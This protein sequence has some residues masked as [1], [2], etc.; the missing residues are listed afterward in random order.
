[1]LARHG[2]PAADLEDLCHEVFLI[3]GQRLSSVTRPEFLLF[4][5]RGVAWRV[6]VAHRRRNRRRT[7]P[8]TGDTADQASESN[9][10]ADEL[11]R[12]QQHDL[13]VRAIEHLDLFERDALILH[14]LAELPLVEV[15]RLANCDPKTARKRLRTAERRVKAW[16]R[17]AL[18]EGTRVCAP[19]AVAPLRT[20]KVNVPPRSPSLPSFHGAKLLADGPTL[21]TALLGNV[22][23]AVWSVRVTAVELDL[24]EE[25]ANLALAMVGGPFLH[26]AI[27]E[28]RC[29][30][31]GVH[32]RARM[33]AMLRMF[34]RDVIAY[35]TVMK[36][37]LAPLVRPVI[38]AL[39]V[40]ARPGFPLAFF[41]GMSA[42]AAWLSEKVP[43]HSFPDADR[44]MATAAWLR[45]RANDRGVQFSFPDRARSEH[46]PE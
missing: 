29:R 3:A 28:P 44:L 19:A 17:R 39:S 38:T 12:A 6:A 14:A 11:A 16:L 21:W 25:T 42:C 27:V 26:V 4:W 22:V 31:A 23:F 18:L 45:A 10:P 2:V 34:T 13:L 20:S 40:M 5:L 15:A 37:G 1:M 33:V 7:E 24:L 46:F 8:L 43:E 30:A 9:T 32:E 41:D 35:A 36:G